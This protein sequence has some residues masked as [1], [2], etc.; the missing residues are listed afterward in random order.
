MGDAWQQRID[1]AAELAA[2][3]EAGSEMLDTYVLLLAIQRDGYHALR[4]KADAITGQIELDLEILR[5]CA[6]AM[7]A[8]VHDHT[9]V[10]SLAQSTLYV[11]GDDAG[12]GM[13]APLVDGWHAREPPFYARLVL[14]PYA[15]CLASLD[16]RPNRDLRLTGS[17]CPF[18][19]GPPQ[20]S[21]LHADSNAAGGG[22]SLLCAM[23]ATT[24]PLRRVLCPSCGEEDERQLGYFQAPEFEHL[25]V[26]ACDTCKRYL[27]AV[28]LTRNGLAVPAVDE[29]A[30]APLD[31]WAGSAGYLKISLNLI[32]L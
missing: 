14:Q 16:R 2:R 18:C 26:D 23:C 4:E 13:D 8:A 32:G 17:V 10:P 22:R 1:R 9:R 31:L 25:R 5:P 12:A 19:G 3:H 7:L 28:D 20:L 21:I 24:W 27:K 11:A 15:E 29:V 30:G 6:I